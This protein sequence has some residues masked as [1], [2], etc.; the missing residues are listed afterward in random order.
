MIATR[1]E[2]YIYLYDSRKRYFSIIIKV[3]LIIYSQRNFYSLFFIQK[4]KQ[5]AVKPREKLACIAS[6]NS[7][8]AS[9]FLVLLFSFNVAFAWFKSAK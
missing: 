7:Q 4:L 6:Y 3:S 9:I 2:E 5:F 1:E 8:E